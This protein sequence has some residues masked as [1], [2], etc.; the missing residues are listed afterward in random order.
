[1]T[2]LMPT[3]FSW[4]CRNCAWR[5]ATD[6]V[7]TIRCTVGLEIPDDATS[8]LA[9]VGLYGVHLTLGSYQALE[10]EIGVHPGSTVPPNTTLFIAFRSIASSNAFLR[11]ALEAI[12]EPTF[13]YGS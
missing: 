2:T 6:P 1:M 4:A 9:S 13:V 10:G 7:G 8:F 3:A 11:L 5:S 12:D